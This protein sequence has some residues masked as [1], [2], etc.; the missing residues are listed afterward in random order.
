M[1][2]PVKYQI[3]IHTLRM[4]IGRGV[5]RYYFQYSG[6]SYQFLIV[7]RVRKTCTTNSDMTTKLR[8]NKYFIILDIFNGMWVVIAFALNDDFNFFLNVYK[9][10]CLMSIINSKLFNYFFVSVNCFLKI[11]YANGI[12]SNNYTE[13]DS[14]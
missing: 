7:F 2:F 13:R 4:C 8:C 9:S 5:T 14:S 6:F 3:K 11:I 12:Q 10:I 1:H